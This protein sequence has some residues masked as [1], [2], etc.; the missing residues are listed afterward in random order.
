MEYEIAIE[1]AL[2]RDT[3]LITVLKPARFITSLEKP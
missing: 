1:D 3:D 2:G